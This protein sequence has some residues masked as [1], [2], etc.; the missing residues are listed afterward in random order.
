[1]LVALDQ[2]GK[3]IILSRSITKTALQQMRHESFFCPQ[4]QQPVRLKAGAVKIPHFAHEAN[5]ECS[6]SFAE[7][8]SLPHLLGKSQ[9]FEHLSTL[10]EVKLE[11]Y[12]PALKQRPDLLIQ[13]KYQYALEFQCSRLD[14]Q[15]FY[16]RTEGYKKH[17]IYPI[18][19]VKTPNIP[20]MENQVRKASFNLFFQQFIQ[21][22]TL[23]TYDV[24]SMHFIYFYPLLYLQGNSFLYMTRNL[25]LKQ[26]IFPFYYPKPISLALFQQLFE[27]YQQ[28]RKQFLHSRLFYSRKGVS[29][30]FLRAIY[31]MRLNREQLPYFIGVPI[32]FAQAIPVFSAEWQL[33]LFYFKHQH[34]FAWSAFRPVIIHSFLQWGKLPETEEAFQAVACYIQ[35]MQCLNI[36]NLY[37][38][39]EPPLF[40]QALYDDFFAFKTKA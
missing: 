7:G 10:Y 12:L 28:Y 33:L 39:C 31:E 34:Q 40:M 3:T 21:Q 4:C 36:Q 32:K 15:L 26:Q 6:H 23:I 2:S 17:H 11:P 35:L 22:Q 37:T 20:L 5:S 38:F 27:A 30:L 8:E 24:E 13:K 1:M 19:L 14:P 25:P 18:W 29:D 9:L 16:Q